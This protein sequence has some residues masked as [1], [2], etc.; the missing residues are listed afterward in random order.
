MDPN[1]HLREAIKLAKKIESADFDDHDA[2]DLAQ[3]V[4]DLHE[5]M[6]RG[7]ALPKMWNTNR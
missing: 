7:G 2:D 3:H 5:W 4:L 6:C 1:E